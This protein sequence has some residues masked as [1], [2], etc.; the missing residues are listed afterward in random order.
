MLVSQEWGTLRKDSL[1]TCSLWENL[2]TFWKNL[3]AAHSTR[4]CAS[5][6]WFPSSINVTSEWTGF[7]SAF[8]QSELNVDVIISTHGAF[9]VRVRYSTVR[10]IPPLVFYKKRGGGLKIRVSTIKCHPPAGGMTGGKGTAFFFFDKNPPNPP[11]DFAFFL[12]WLHSDARLIWVKK[13]NMLLYDK[14]STYKRIGRHTDIYIQ[15][16]TYFASW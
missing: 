10:A 8:V 1:P 16:E 14:D 6:L 11:W 9:P 2:K 13:E 12:L 15:A 3:E 4:R 7:C 5:S